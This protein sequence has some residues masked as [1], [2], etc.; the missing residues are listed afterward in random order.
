ML[1]SDF[2]SLIFSFH[3]F[4]GS[5]IFSIML[6]IWNQNTSLWGLIRQWEAQ[7]GMEMGDERLERG[8]Q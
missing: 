6:K 8:I 4:Y 3:Y 5:Y 1:S 2:C 7:E